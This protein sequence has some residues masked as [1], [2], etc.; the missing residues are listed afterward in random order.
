MRASAARHAT[1]PVKVAIDFPAPLFRK[2]NR[3]RMN[4]PST[5]PA[6]SVRGRDLP[7]SED[8]ENL[9]AR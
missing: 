6:H 5:K 1:R 7:A 9:S 2:R 4:Y 3:R 8:R